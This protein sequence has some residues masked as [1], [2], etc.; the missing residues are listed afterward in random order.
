MQRTT[1][2]GQGP[3][4]ILAWIGRVL[5]SLIVPIITFVV[6]WQVFLFLRDSEAPKLVIAIVAIIWGVGGVAILFVLSNWITERLPDAWRAR[7]QPYVFVGPA[8]VML[9]WFLALPTIRSFWQSFFD[10][11]STN[12]VGLQNYVYAFTN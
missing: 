9:G 1:T 10:A 8:L 7:I 12:F 3:T 11:T 4:S 2:V 6:L 5:V